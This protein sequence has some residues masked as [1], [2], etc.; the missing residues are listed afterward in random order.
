MN[1]HL[2]LPTN[3]LLALALLA[4]L[5]TTGFAE[6]ETRTWVDSSG[7]HRTEATLI[8]V[9]GDNVDLRTTDGRTIT[10]QINRLS[11]ADRDYLA[12]RNQSDD[13]AATR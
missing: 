9:D 4:T 5:A 7:Q 6:E 13:D 10:V 1:R 2:F 8:K 11:K 12:A 3:A